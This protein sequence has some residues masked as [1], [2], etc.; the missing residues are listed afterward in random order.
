MSRFSIFFTP[1]GSVLFES[2]PFLV[3]VRKNQFHA[4]RN[5][6]FHTDVRVIVRKTALIVRMI[7]ICAFVCKLCGM[8]LSAYDSIA[9][10]SSVMHGEY[11]IEDVAISTLTLVGPNGVQGKVP[12]KLTD[13]EVAKLQK[14]AN[15]LKEVISQIEL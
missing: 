1:V 5:R 14:S 15:S 7:K 13:E 8:L 4:F 12:L 11:G 2:S 6:P 10:V 3:F 9:T